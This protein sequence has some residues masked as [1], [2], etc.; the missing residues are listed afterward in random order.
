[1][2]SFIKLLAFLFAIVLKLLLLFPHCFKIRL[3]LEAFEKIVDTVVRL[4]LHKKLGY[5][6]TS[7]NEFSVPFNIS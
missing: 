7:V 5:L 2:Q 4:D 3:K 6:N 1:M